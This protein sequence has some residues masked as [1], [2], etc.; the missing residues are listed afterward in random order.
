MEDEQKKPV[1]S[2]LHVQLKANEELELKGTP[3][4][5]KNS[6]PFT[7][8]LHIYTQEYKEQRKKGRMA[9]AAIDHHRPPKR[10]L[11]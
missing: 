1:G 2:G 6:G 11:Y 3:Y 4:I 8:S 7:T 9:Q 5:I 10:K